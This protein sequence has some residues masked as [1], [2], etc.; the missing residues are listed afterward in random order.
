MSHTR[1]ALRAIALLTAALLLSGC[2]VVPEPAYYHPHR[3]Y[4][5]GWR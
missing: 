4:Y 2:V 3:V 5:Y 1:T